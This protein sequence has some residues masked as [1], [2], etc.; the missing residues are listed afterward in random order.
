MFPHHPVSSVLRLLRLS[1][2]ALLLFCSAE[3]SK[4]LIVDATVTGN[5]PTV[6]S[7]SIVDG[8][9]AVAWANS[10]L[11]VAPWMNSPLTSVKYARALDA[12]GSAWGEPVTLYTATAGGPSFTTHKASISLKVVDG[13]P[14]VCFSH[15]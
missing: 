7:T 4:A 5:K 9:P 10:R 2:C 14:A 6:C 3:R 11:T 1:L 13:R 12:D 15:P 8:R